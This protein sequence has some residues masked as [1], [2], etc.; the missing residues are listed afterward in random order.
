MPRKPP[1][2]PTTTIAEAPKV[3]K[4][5]NSSPERIALRHVE[6]FRKLEE[7]LENE[8]KRH[9]DKCREIAAET[10]KH[11][12]Q[13]KKLQPLVTEAYDRFIGN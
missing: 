10:D 5:R 3:K 7:R 13:V 6:A 9:E 1:S 8:T 12:E 4:V 2:E 11:D